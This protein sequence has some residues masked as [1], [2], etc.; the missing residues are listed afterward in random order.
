MFIPGI[1]S[2]APGAGLV[3]GIGIFIPGIF[4]CCGEVLGEAAGIGMFI[5]IF[6]FGEL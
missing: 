3:F 4:L 1:F 6:C 2:I 5:S